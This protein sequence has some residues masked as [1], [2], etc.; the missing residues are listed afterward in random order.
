MRSAVAC[1]LAVAA[2]V[3]VLAQ[4]RPGD[5]RIA[6]AGVRIGYD[7]IVPPERWSPLLVTIKPGDKPQ[8]LVL[9]VRYDQDPTQE[10][11][12]RTP[13]TTT[14]GVTVTVPMLVCPPQGV[15]RI[16]VNLSTEG[17]TLS[18]AA[19]ARSPR[20]DEI[21]LLQSLDSGALLVGTLGQRV[22]ESVIEPW[23]EVKGS[24]YNRSGLD[25]AA[26]VQLRADDLAES[27]ACFDGLN[28]VIARQS[29]LERLPVPTLDAL[30]TWVSGGGRLVLIADGPGD[31]WR[32]FVPRGVY[33]GDLRPVSPPASLSRSLPAGVR[34]ADSLIA[35]PVTIDGDGAAR[36][37]TVHHSLTEAGSGGGSLVADGTYGCGITVLVGFDPALASAV[38]NDAN[39]KALWTSLLSTA[40]PDRR[41][42]AD[43]VA[44]EYGYYSYM[45]S[46]GDG[47]VGSSAL[48]TTV[49][50][51]CDVPPV[52]PWAYVMIVVLS[53]ALA[54][55]VSLGDYIVLGRLKWRHRS[56]LSAA[57]WITVCGLLAWALPN[58]VRGNAT[59]IGRA[60]V[61]DVPPPVGAAG[62]TAW[63]T[64]VTAIFAARTT[65]A[66]LLESGPSRSDVSGYWRGVSVLEVYAFYRNQ[67]R[68]VVNDLPLL[69]RVSALDGSAAAVVPMGDGVPLR[70]WTLRT[71]QDFGPL[72][73]GRAV[74][75][76]RFEPGGSRGSFRMS[77]LAAGARV[78]SAAAQTSDGWAPLSVRTDRGAAGSSGSAV[79]MTIDASPSEQLKGWKSVALK[80]RDDQPY[81]NVYDVYSGDPT[82]GRR[83]LLLDGARR[84]T[85]AFDALAASGQYAVVHLLV[86]APPDIT[87]TIPHSP[88]GVFLYRIAVPLTESAPPVPT[89]AP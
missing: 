55:A 5:A 54:L 37:W 23:K 35:R 13:V 68:P 60:V 30:S 44:G 74:P 29:T 58:I 11:V 75:S 20:N 17:R 18:R 82:D 76:G 12:I 24:A 42:E 40:L 87:T 52:P 8:S 56:W 73:G 15:E 34:V 22:P 84:R 50:A 79:T 2:A 33:A 78:L 48:R 26:L 89:G 45:T 57:V 41:L 71:L 19:F 63:R 31:A 43:S 14:P 46:S 39:V 85:P 49:D 62:G 25:R 7:G 38:L 86:E 69:Q 81:P 36:G 1:V 10:A 16:S 80:R 27:W 83:Y 32:K 51:L 67:S 77:G 4:A 53:A 72:K 70:Q 28:V 3:P 47:V 61:I 64:G 66:P 6:P 9:T 65:D 21:N 59:T 88:R